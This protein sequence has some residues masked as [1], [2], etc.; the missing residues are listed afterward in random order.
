MNNNYDNQNKENGGYNDG[1]V[2][3]TS[4]NTTPVS[5]QDTMLNRER[6]N[7]VSATLQANEAIDETKARD[8]NDQIANKKMN[9]LKLGIIV[10]VI[11]LLTG[12]ITYFGYH[13]VKRIMTY[14]DPITTEPTRST[15]PANKVMTFLEKNRVHKFESD[16][17]FTINNIGYDHYILLLAPNNTDLKDNN[18]YYLLIIG[19]EAGLNTESGTYTIENDTIKVGNY[20]LK[21]NDDHLYLDTYDLKLKIMDTEMKYYTYNDEVNA[22]TLIING[23][24][25]YEYAL[26]I[27]SNLNRTNIYR[28]SFIEDRE[29]IRLEDDKLF[30]K[31]EVGVNYNG[32]E[33]SIGQ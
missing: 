7:I 28:S 5:A 1:I 15:R 22:Y 31:S 3:P 25:K 19:N 6:E 24:P 29:N 18:N 32:K 26:F 27:D 12:I 23:T 13:I 30:L 8:V 14:D 11:L 17:E 16:Q 4:V 2:Q 9:P 20:T 21:I 10:V 33:M